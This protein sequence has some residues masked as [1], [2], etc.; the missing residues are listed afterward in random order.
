MHHLLSMFFKDLNKT[1]LADNT[2]VIFAARHGED[3]DALYKL[4]RTD[5]YYQTTIEVPVFFVVAERQ[6]Q[7]LGDSFARLQSMLGCAWC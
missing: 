2:I 1:S 4:H 3:L 6:R 5:S 7:R